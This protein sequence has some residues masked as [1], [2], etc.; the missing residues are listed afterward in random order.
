MPLKFIPS[1]QVERVDSHV[2]EKTETD[3]QITRTKHEIE[4]GSYAH[5]IKTVRGETLMSTTLGDISLHDRSMYYW[6]PAVQTPIEQH[7]Y[8]DDMQPP[9]FSLLDASHMSAIDFFYFY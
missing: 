8:F 1:S 3:P 2:D 7:M 6:A 9:S 4:Q 5:H